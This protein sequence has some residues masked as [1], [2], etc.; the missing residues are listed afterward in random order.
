MTAWL[1]WFQLVGLASVAVIC[2]VAVFSVVMRPPRWAD[3]RRRSS[4]RCR[5]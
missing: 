1:G 5:V 2:A 3:R 4:S